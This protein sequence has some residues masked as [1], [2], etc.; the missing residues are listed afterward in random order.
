MIAKLSIIAGVLKLLRWS[1]RQYKLF[2]VMLVLTDLGISIYLPSITSLYN[3]GSNKPPT[4]L[5]TI[6]RDQQAHP[7]QLRCPTVLQSPPCSQ[8]KYHRV[9]CGLQR[10]ELSSAAL[11]LRNNRHRLHRIFIVGSGIQETEF[12]LVEQTVMI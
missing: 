11:P 8:L 2:L 4:H 12:G 6:T 3:S 7:Y 10:W 1:R 9:G 5:A